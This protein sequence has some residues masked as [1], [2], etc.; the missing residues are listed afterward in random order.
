MR[1]IVGDGLTLEPQTAAHA[2]QMFAVLSDPAIYEHENKPPPSL[3]WLRARFSR[4]ESR[5]S[6]DGS[7]QWL[8]W[9]IRVPSSELVGYVQATVRPSGH[10]AIAYELSSAYWGRGL[11]RRAIQAMIAELGEH[12]HIRTVTAVLKSENRRSLGLL[13]RLGFS[14]ASPESHARHNVEP[15]EILMQREVRADEPNAQ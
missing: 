6:A 2:V 9:V 5:H 3:E 12:Y 15:G 4:L 8:N 14:L 7:E 10:A 1:A 13:E 11:A